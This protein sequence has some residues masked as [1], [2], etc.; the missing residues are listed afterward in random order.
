M[1]T[2]CFLV[3]K[4]QLQNNYLM[5]KKLLL[6]INAVFLGAITPQKYI[7][8]FKWPINFNESFIYDIWCVIVEWNLN[9]I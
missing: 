1:Y 8:K 6:I 4:S 7:L 2:E 3:K 5:N 9:F